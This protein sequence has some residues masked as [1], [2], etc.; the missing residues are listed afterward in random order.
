MAY[1]SLAKLA[2]P[3]VVLLIALLSYASQYL[4]YAIEPGPLDSRQTKIFN[5]LVICLWISYARACTTSPGSVPKDWSPESNAE[6]KKLSDG[7]VQT[8]QRY[9]RK[10]DALKPPRSHHCKICK[11]YVCRN[12]RFRRQRLT[13]PAKMH[14]QDGPS[15]SL[16]LQLCI[17]LHVSPFHAFSVVCCIRNDLP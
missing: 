6:D 9:C 17:S 8:R 3:A 2:V 13:L 10:C 7:K 5:L 12:G 1:P 11:R 14:S 4:F 15:L 16:D